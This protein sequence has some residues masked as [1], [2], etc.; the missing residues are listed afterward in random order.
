M[1]LRNINWKLTNEEIASPI[2]GRRVLE[3]FGCDNR[4]MSMAARDRYDDD[5]D[6]EDQLKRDGNQE[7]SERT[8]AALF[9]K[10][11][12]HNHGQV[13]DDRI[14]RDDVNVDLVDDRKES[15]EEELVKRVKETAENGLS[16]K[17]ENRLEEVTK[18]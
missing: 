9:G 15:I 18:N 1:I 12:F 17:D 13:E 16:R 7:E 6:A 4:A 2:L 11:V 5:I 3:S 8:L 10:S 14:G